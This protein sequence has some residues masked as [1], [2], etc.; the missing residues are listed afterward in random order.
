[1]LLE[2]PTKYGTSANLPDVFQA[3][4]N[5]DMYILECIKECIRNQDYSSMINFYSSHR[6]KALSTQSKALLTGLHSKGRKNATAKTIAR[7]S[8]RRIGAF[9]LQAMLEFAAKKDQLNTIEVIS[10]VFSHYFFAEYHSFESL[11]L[12]PEHNLLDMTTNCKFSLFVISGDFIFYM[13]N[14]KTLNFC[15]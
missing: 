6:S 7:D 13:I 14:I 12:L 11:E 10:R 3:I 15:F 5:E 8:F 4:L 1:M 9:P 2:E